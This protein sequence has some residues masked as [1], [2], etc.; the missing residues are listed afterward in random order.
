MLRQLRSIVRTTA[1]KAVEKI[2]YGMPYYSYRGRLVYFAA[3]KEHVSLFARGAAMKG[4]AREVKPYR[5]SSATLRLPLGSKLPVTLV[6]K[7]VKARV[8]DNEAKQKGQGR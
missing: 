7:L 2:G 5:T 1:P 4:F 8:K 6:R 3:F